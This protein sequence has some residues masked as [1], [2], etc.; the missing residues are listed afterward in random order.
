V[1]GYVQVRIEAAAFNPLD[2]KIYDYGGG[3]VEKYPT[4]LGVDAAGEVTKTDSA[5]SKFEV[6]D[7]VTFICT[8]N[9]PEGIHLGDRGAFQQYALADIRLTAKVKSFG[10]P[11]SLIQSIF[12]HRSLRMLTMTRRRRSPSRATR[13]LVRST[14]S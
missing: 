12:I 2:Y 5:D 7:R 4:V 1:K 10:I 9:S 11:L 6:G 14:A 8:A 13:R 3:F